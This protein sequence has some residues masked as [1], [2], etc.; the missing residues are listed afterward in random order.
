MCIIGASGKL[1]QYMIQQA[2]D[3]GYEVVGVWR[4]ES[5]GKLDRFSGCITVVPGATDDRGVISRAVAGRNA[6]LTVLVPRGVHHYASRTTQ[7]LLATTHSPGATVPC[8]WHIT[9]DGR[10]VYS[11]KLKAF[12]KIGGGLAR[13]A[14]VADLDDQVQAC[15]RMFTSSTRSTVVRA[16][17]LAEGESQGLA[18]WSRHVANPILESN[19]TRCVDF[20]L[21]MVAAIENDEL[22]QERQLSSAARH[23]QH[24]R[25]VMSHLPEVPRDRGGD[26]ARPH[27]P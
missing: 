19:I 1:G 3:K 13:L 16:S 18:V 12:V 21:F 5:V 7:A 27:H 6:V 17:D 26:F 15:R 4:A 22:I 14:G 11:V 9:R 20:A 24:L 10:D 2:L 23:L 25:T 8:G